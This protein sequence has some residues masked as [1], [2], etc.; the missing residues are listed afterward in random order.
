[1][2]F[3]PSSSPL[4]VSAV[5]ALVG[6]VLALLGSLTK[7]DSL[8]ESLGSNAL[9]EFVYG[10]VLLVWPFQ[11]LGV[12]EAVVGWIGAAV[13][14]VGANILLFTLIGWLGFRFRQQP[15]LLAILWGA[16]VI[17]LTVVAWWASGNDAH[18]VNI[19]SLAVAALFYGALVWVVSR[20]KMMHGGK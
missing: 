14:T 3:K 11:P 1:M 8:D 20:E 13:I 18:F 10:I 12:L 16:V 7:L 2:T 9:S 19:P 15:V 5:A 17:P 4:L 6:P